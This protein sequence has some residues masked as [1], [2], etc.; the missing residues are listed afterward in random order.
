VIDLEEALAIVRGI[1]RGCSEETV[2]LGHAQGRVLARPLLS[3]T[4]SPPFDKATMDGF[5]VGVDDESPAY[6]VVETVAAGAMPSRTVHAGECARIM[7][8]AALPA[9]AGRVIRK[10]FVEERGGTMRILT[11]E[12]GPN[13][14]LRGAGLRAGQHL[15]TP[16]ALRAHDIGILA[17]SGIQR[18]EVAALPTIGIISTGSEIRAPGAS[19]KPG[20][21][22]DSNGP[23]LAAQCAALRWPTRSFGIVPDEAGVLRSALEAGLAA[24]DVVLVSGGVSVGDFDLVPQCL[25]ELGAM[26]LF[27]GVAVKP[28]KPT[29][30]ARRADRF[31]FGM[32][33]NPVSAF[34]IFELFVKTLVYRWMGIDWEPPLFRAVLDRPLRRKDTERVE[35]LPVSVRAGRATPIGLQGSWN[36][37][38]LGDADG[39]VRMERG[40]AEIPE[41]TET[42]VRPVWS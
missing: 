38:A 27:H 32:P 41:G 25:V 15:L 26:I 22:Y 18:V 6:R 2:D 35:F 42:Y 34:V 30:L 16:R 40:V 31:I 21:I 24:C 4:D 7:T 29:L 1:P 12:R 9:G 17:A 33:G 8:G 23:Q 20:Q 19:L 14:V 39:L 10:E 3:P 37:N 5:A 11:A 13:V 28:G 36:L